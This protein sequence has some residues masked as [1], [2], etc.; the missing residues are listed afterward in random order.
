M[1]QFPVI[2][3]IVWGKGRINKFAADPSEPRREA[4]FP[5]IV[6]T[7]KRR[8]RPQRLAVNSG[9]TIEPRTRVAL[10]IE[11]RFGGGSDGLGK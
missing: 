8:G 7:Q 6:V 5:Y 4:I 3:V 11:S 2:E 9:S 1:P 10:Y